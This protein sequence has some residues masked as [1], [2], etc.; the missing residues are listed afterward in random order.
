MILLF[1]FL[2]ACSQLANLRL[3]G[4]TTTA[5]NKTPVILQRQQVMSNIATWQ[6]W[7]LFILP[8]VCTWQW[9][10]ETLNCCNLE[11]SKCASI[12][13]T[14][15][16]PRICN[17]GNTG[18]VCPSPPLPLSDMGQWR[19]RESAGLGSCQEFSFNNFFF[20]LPWFCLE[21]YCFPPHLSPPSS[22]FKWLQEREG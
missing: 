6:E 21:K 14:T 18:K 8:S 10:S 9:N 15:T 7:N 13:I 17:G 22:P 1:N 4:R 3:A 20:Q 12:S 5:K 2:C 11:T 16:A 19:V